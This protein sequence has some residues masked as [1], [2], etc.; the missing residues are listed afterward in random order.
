MF[1]FTIRELVLLT[2]VV[3]VGAG[4]WIDRAMLRV[5][6][7]N[8]HDTQ[9]RA[10]SEIGYGTIGPCTNAKERAWF[11]AMSEWHRNASE[12][13]RLVLWRPWQRFSLPQRPRLDDSK[14]K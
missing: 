13:N 14:P 2:L 10:C 7:A 11:L 6:G 3:A 4:W 5:S 9:C 8:Y 1:R 12:T